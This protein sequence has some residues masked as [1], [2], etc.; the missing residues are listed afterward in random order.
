MDAYGFIIG[1][2]GIILLSFLF[3]QIARKTRIPAVLML[4]GL[5]IGLQYL[6]RWAGFREINFFP[7]LEV[8][9]IVGLI[10]IVLE[11]ALELELTRKKV[12][13]ILKSAAVSALGLAVSVLAA[14]LIIRVFHPGMHM[15]QAVLYATP[16]SILSS[17]I[18]IPSVSHME[19]HQKEFLI[20]ESTLSDILGIM[21]FYFIV[22][23][24]DPVSLKG[25]HP[26]T[27]FLGGFAITLVVSLIA[28]YFLIAIFQYIS[29]GPKL[30]L[31]I[32]ILLLLYAISKKAHLSPLIIILMFGLMVRNAPLFFRWGLQR[33]LIREKFHDLEKGLHNLTMETAFVVRTFFFVI[34]GASIALAG[35]LSIKVIVVSL[36]LLGSIYLVRFLVLAL[37]LGK[38]VTPSVWVAPRGLIT[39]LLFYAIPEELTFPDFDSGILLFIILASSVV[40]TLGMIYGKKPDTSGA[41]EDELIASTPDADP[42]LALEELDS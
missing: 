13:V 29:A 17:A 20:Y 12:P 26:V 42:G 27:A 9:G 25:P 30:F 16:L 22:G 28:G 19:E 7:A 24:L 35:L 33:F 14:A 38:Q 6:M 40:M 36:V 5:G 8:L 23:F 4:I 37:F 11:A 41:N 34:F 31:L 15:S 10:M 1:A 3:S 2:S 21:L 39:V 18:I 32:A